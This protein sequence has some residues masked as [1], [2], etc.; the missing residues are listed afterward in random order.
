MKKSLKLKIKSNKK[1]IN[2]IK[3]ILESKIFRSYLK[4]ENKYFI[5]SNNLNLKNNNLIKIIIRNLK[6]KNNNKFNLYYLCKKKYY[7]KYYRKNWNNRKKNNFFYYYSKQKKNYFNFYLLDLFFFKKYFYKKKKKKYLLF[8]SLN[9]LFWCNSY[10]G[11]T[12]KKWNKNMSLYILNCKNGIFYLN[13][14][15]SLYLTRKFFKLLTI[16]YVKR[17]FIFIYIPNTLKIL[18][19]IISNK[20]IFITNQWLFGFVTNLKEALKVKKKKYIKLKKKLRIPFLII[21]LN[22]NLRN[23]DIILRESHTIRMLSLGLIDTDCE[24][25]LCSY[26]IPINNKSFEVIFFYYRLI[27]SYF[28]LLKKK[29][30]KNFYEQLMF[31]YKEDNKKFLEEKEEE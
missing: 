18:F 21:I 2:F 14:N 6:K 24:P 16:V 10:L 26:F 25:L 30:K 27:I 22:I 28:L 15:Y 23:Y 11:S 31:F 4:F 7:K 3:K 13:I 20:H 1:K 19:N 8:L 12:K 29:E 17:K 9:Q 5:K